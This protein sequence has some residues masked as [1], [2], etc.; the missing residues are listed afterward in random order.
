MTFKGGSWKAKQ[1]RNEI[2][3]L[4]HPGKDAVEE[5]KANAR[6]V[7]R[8]LGDDGVTKFFRETERRSNIPD[9]RLGWIL[10]DVLAEASL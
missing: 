10:R 5:L 2:I 4:Y 7:R 3:H 6:E 8:K 1:G 9:G